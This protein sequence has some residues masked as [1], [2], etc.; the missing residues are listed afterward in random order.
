MSEA[1]RTDHGRRLAESLRRA[2]ELAEQESD[3]DVRA[4]PRTLPEENGGFVD[5]V[6]AR[7]HLDEMCPSGTSPLGPYIPVT[8]RDRVVTLGGEAAF[9]KFPQY[10][11]DAFPRFQE[12]HVLALLKLARKQVRQDIVH[13]ILRQYWLRLT[14]IAATAATLFQYGAEAFAWVETHLPALRGLWQLLRT[15]SA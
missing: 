8:G 3:D 1:D 12:E 13:A 14:A 7:Q 5:G 6:K 15:G 10:W 4:G 9:A 2:A 11:L